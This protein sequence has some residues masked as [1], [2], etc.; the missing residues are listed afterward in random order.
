MVVGWK[1]IP[2]MFALKQLEGGTISNIKFVIM[3]ALM[4]FGGLTNEQNVEH[5]VC[6]RTNGIST[7]QGVRSRVITSLKTQHALYFIGI[8]CMVH[9]TNL[10]MQSL[11]SMPMVSK[12]EDLFQSLYGYFFNS[13]KQHLEF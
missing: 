11:S 12:L 3:V 9:R 4:T 6:L 1:R 2:I 7:F 8:H 13:P 5:L 10:I